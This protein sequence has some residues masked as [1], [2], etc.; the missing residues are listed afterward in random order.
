MKVIFQVYLAPCSIDK[1]NPQTLNIY[2]KIVL[3]KNTT[4][5]ITLISPKLS[6]QKQNCIVNYMAVLY[7]IL[8]LQEK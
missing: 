8:Y 2:F 7:I 4:T 5:N 3:S 1:E 6:G